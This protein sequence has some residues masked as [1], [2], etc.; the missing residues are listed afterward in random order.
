MQQF[1][2]GHINTENREL[3]IYKESNDASVLRV[4]DYDNARVNLPSV[5][6]K[7]LSEP[8]DLSSQNISLSAQLLPQAPLSLHLLLRNT[9]FAIK[10]GGTQKGER[11]SY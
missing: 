11:G 6:L 3:K 8:K 1:H 5:Y 9:L 2:K 4:S 10:P 7:L